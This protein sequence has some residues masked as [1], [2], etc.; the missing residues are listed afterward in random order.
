MN[1]AKEP[2]A[3]LDMIGE[4]DIVMVSYEQGYVRNRPPKMD[5]LR[6]AKEAAKSADVVLFFGGL[7]E[8]SESEGLDRTHMMMPDAQGMLIDELSTVNE[9]LVVVLSAGSAIEMPW[10]P[11][12]R[13]LSSP[14]SKNRFRNSS[15]DTSQ[16]C[17]ACSFSLSL[18]M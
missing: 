6:K 12:S 2:E 18:A 1:P 14:C 8:I 11:P 5:L 7:D 3:I 16:C 15:P 4:Y 13:L 10:H 17:P 9:N